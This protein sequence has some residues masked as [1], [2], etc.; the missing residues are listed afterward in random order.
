VPRDRRARR[1]RHPV[2]RR[3]GRK[4][5]AGE[6]LAVLLRLPRGPAGGG[7]PP[8]VKRRDRGPGGGRGRDQRPVGATGADHHPVAHRVSAGRSRGRPALDRIVALRHPRR[9]NA[10]R[11]ATRQHR[12]APAGG[13]RG[14]ARHRAGHLQRPVRPGQDRGA[15]HRRRG[16]DGYPA[17]A[18][19]PADHPGRRGA[20]RHDRPARHAQPGYWVTALRSWVRRLTA[21]PPVPHPT[22]YPPPIRWPPGSARPVP[23][24]DAGRCHRVPERTGTT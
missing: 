23:R 19:R 6:H 9:G 7:V 1:G 24:L 15:H 11:R 14:A 16:R 21:T 20:G 13:R 17:V 3:G 22:R 12:L 18:G 5:R 4:R 10:G 2:R 8:R